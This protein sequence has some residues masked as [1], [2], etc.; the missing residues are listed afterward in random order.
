MGAPEHNA[1]SR[2]RPDP[3][4]GRSAIDRALVEFTDGARRDRSRRSRQ[5]HLDRRVVAELSGTFL[6]TLVDLLE[7]GAPAVFVA[8]SGV[9]H[10]GIVAAVGRDVIVLRPPGDTRRILLAPAFVEAIRRPEPARPREGPVVAD[11]PGLGSLLDDMAGDR[12]RISVTTFGGNRFMGT[13][14][15]VGED[16]IEMK[17]D[18]GGD[19][20][21]LA[22]PAV[23]E[24]VVEP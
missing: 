20:M 1:G 11:G 10:R 13:L 2:D 6:G 7:S 23:A 4:A 8:G 14:R 15:A 16:Q 24:A 21:T 22:L 17:L 9:H 3:A 18:G 5:E 19:S 12:P